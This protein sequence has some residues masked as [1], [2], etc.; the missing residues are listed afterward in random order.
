MT[1]EDCYNFLREITL[2]DDSLVHAKNIL[3]KKYDSRRLEVLDKIVVEYVKYYRE[4]KKL[5]GYS[6]DIVKRRV[7]LL[8]SYYNYIFEN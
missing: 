3:K 4:N 6:Q 5:C 7:E 1:P 8:N 2:H